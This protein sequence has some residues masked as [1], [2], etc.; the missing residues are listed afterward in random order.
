[1]PA[2]TLCLVPCASTDPVPCANT[3]P[4]PCAST[5]PVPCAST[6]PV[7]C[8]STDPVPCASTDPVPC[9]STDPVPCVLV[10]GN[11]HRVRQECWPRHSVRDSAHHHGDPVGEWPESPGHQHS[12]ALPF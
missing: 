10:G 9:A 7:P 6:D 4:V 5:D 11:K 2:L 3:D 1:M 12:G 8:A